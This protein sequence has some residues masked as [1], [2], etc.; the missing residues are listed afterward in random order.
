MNF[1]RKFFTATNDGKLE[2]KQLPWLAL[3]AL[4]QLDNILTDSNE[5][6]V[7]IFK[8]STR[9]GTSSM[10]LRQFERAF[11]IPENSV[12]LYFL[13]LLSYRSIS[14]EISIRFQVLHQSPQMIIIKNQ[15]TVHHASHY[16]ISAS[17]IEKF[18]L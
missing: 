8:H 4:E 9:C 11:E 15:K 16:Q 3:T 12:Y 2:K 10:V 18:V 14:D 6:P 17:D 13:D 5:K 1:L 7:V